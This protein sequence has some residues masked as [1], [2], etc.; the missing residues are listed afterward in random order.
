MRVVEYLICCPVVSCFHNCRQT[1]AGACEIG[2]QG[3][4]FIDGFESGRGRYI[5]PERE[6]NRRVRNSRRKWRE[7]Q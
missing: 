7:I 4:Q 5:G 2:Y 1:C 6:S 3:G